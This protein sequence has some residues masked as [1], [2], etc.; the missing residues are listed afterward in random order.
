M[1]TIKISDLP[2]LTSPAVGDL[3]V[4]V[5]V[6]EALDADKTKSIRLDKVPVTQASQITDGIITEAKLGS[7]SVTEAK[8][9][10]ALKPVTA[11]VLK[12]GDQSV[13][14]AATAHLTGWTVDFDDDSLWSS[15]G[16]FEIAQAGVYCV[17]LNGIVNSSSNMQAR[18]RHLTGS[19]NQWLAVQSHAKTITYTRFFVTGM[20]YCAVGDRLY[21]YVQNDETS[22]ITVR[23]VESYTYNQY[24]QFSLWKVG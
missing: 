19:T 10:N 9:E 11:K 15:S 18:I 4:V 5:D 2:A 24:T 7:G 20:D 8:L 14:S 13:G 23:A 22:S 12:N 3:L 6:S 16:Y 17:L 21:P 1:T